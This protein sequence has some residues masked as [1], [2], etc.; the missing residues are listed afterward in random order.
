MRRPYGLSAVV[1]AA[2]ILVIGL[3][4]SMPRVKAQSGNRE[5]EIKRVNLSTGQANTRT[6]WHLMPRVEYRG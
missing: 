2:V 1:I 6:S 4:Y 3:F 5:V